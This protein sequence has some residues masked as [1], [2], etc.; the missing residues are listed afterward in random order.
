L[1]EV[2]RNFVRKNETCLR[3]QKVVEADVAV[4]ATVKYLILRL[5]DLS[6][7][8]DVDVESMKAQSENL[9]EEYGRVSEERNMM[10][11][12]LRIAGQRVRLTRV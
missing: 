11:K 9:A 5:G 1:G 6:R 2:Q 8:V 3:R 10:E 12:K 4:V 7:L